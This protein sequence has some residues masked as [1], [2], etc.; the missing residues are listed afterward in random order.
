MDIKIIPGKKLEGSISVPP[1]KSVTHRAF[2]MAA[3]A[4]GITTIINPLVSEDT[5]TT[6]N[7]LSQLGVGIKKEKDR[8]IILGTNGNINPDKKQI[9]LNVKESGTSYRFLKAVSFLSSVSIHFT[10]SNRL[11]ERPIKPLEEALLQIPKGE[12]R[13]DSSLSSQFLSA[14]LI[15]SPVLK[16]GLIIHLI[17]RLPS[18][19]YVDITVDLMKKFGVNVNVKDN[20]TYDV[21]PQKYQGVTYR[22]E[23]DY[24]SASYFILANELGAKIK[25]KNLT[26]NS[27]QGDKKIL[28][29][30]KDKKEN[31]DMSFFPDLVPT[32][33][34]LASFNNYKTVIT[35]IKNLRHKESDRIEALQ[36]ELT[37]TGIKINSSENTLEIMGGN[38]KGDIFNTWKDHR[39]AMSLSILACFARGESV[40]KNAEVVNKSYP[41]FW[42]DLKN[43]GA[44]IIVIH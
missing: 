7:C 23:G 12:V 33:S 8:V 42:K 15:I 17:S 28:E 26:E 38:P 39:I 32:V 36:T 19:P 40:I 21:P 2:I 9:T 4:S 29:I 30:I 5:D 41:N 27:V 6:L 22:I 34:V 24:S 3:L 25:F 16:K 43:L 1:S 14:L 44:N 13:L 11:L 10:G 37:K 35:G 18:H 31:I 20:K